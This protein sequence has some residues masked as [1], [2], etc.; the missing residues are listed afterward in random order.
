MV[1]RGGEEGIIFPTFLRRGKGKIL[2]IFKY[3]STEREIG[4]A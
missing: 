2:G 4:K 1:Y 3:T